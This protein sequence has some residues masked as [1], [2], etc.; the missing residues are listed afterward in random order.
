VSSSNAGQ[1]RAPLGVSGLGIGVVI[2]VAVI[3]SV[4]TTLAFGALRPSDSSSAA[5]STE[6]SGSGA[7]GATASEAV[8]ALSN[9]VAAVLSSAVSITTSDGWGSGVVVSDDGWIL[10]NRHVVECDRNVDVTF[11]DGRTDSA[12]VEAIDSLSDLALIRVPSKGL[13]AAALGQSGDLT[14]GQPVAAI[15]NSEGYLAN[16][17]TSGVVSALWRQVY[18]DDE[19]EYRNLIQTDAAIYGGNSGGPLITLAGEVVGID[20]VSAVT[21]E[22]V[23]AEGLSFAIPSDLAAPIVKQA[24]A[25]EKLSRPWLGVRHVPVDGGIVDSERLPV[26]QGA[27]VWPRVGD[28]GA[29]RPAVAA[30]SPAAKA[31]IK[32]GDVITAIDDSPVDDRHPLD[33]VLATF[34]SGEDVILTIVRDSKEMKVPVHLAEREGRPVG[35]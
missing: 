2:A 31:G 1:P 5:T 33:N 11:Q 15:G 21:D 19:G 26:D 8:P 27:L 20:T 32:K 24:I 22:G 14:V 17:V 30:N 34:S 6:P 13:K 35:C 29:T 18:L 9:A 28:N 12:K 10:T 4:A 23:S 3:S 25:G 7:P 16:T